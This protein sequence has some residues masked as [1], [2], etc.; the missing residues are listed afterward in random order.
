M[1]RHKVWFVIK[2][3]TTNEDAWSGSSSILDY[4]TFFMIW[5]W[6]CFWSIVNPLKKSDVS[7]GAN[8]TKLQIDIVKIMSYALALVMMKNV[9]H[10]A[11]CTKLQI[12]MMKIMAYTLALVMMNDVSHGANCT[13]LQIDMVKIKTY[14]IELIMMKD[15]SH[16]ANCTK[17]QITWWFD[18]KISINQYAALR[19]RYREVNSWML[20]KVNWITS[21]KKCQF[22]WGHKNFDFDFLIKSLS[23]R[24]LQ[25]QDANVLVRLH[26]LE[27]NNDRIKDQ[28]QKN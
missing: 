18:K 4:P 2:A 24:A 8:Y 23:I 9:S 15:V 17:L 10:G 25:Q 13:K 12:G 5:Y 3:K 1:K 11:N 21:F 28:L 16:G 27:N 26:N 14:V 6:G 19:Q 20:S 22:W 7:H